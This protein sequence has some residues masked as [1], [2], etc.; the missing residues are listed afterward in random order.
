[1][2]THAFLDA[3]FIWSLGVDALLIPRD[4]RVPRD[5]TD[6]STLQCPDD[7]DT[8]LPT[9]TYGGTGGIFT[10][11]AELLINAPAELIYNTLIDFKSYHIWN[12]FV[13]NVEVPSNVTNT[14]DDVY[15]NMP[16]TFTTSGL[17]PLINTT[18]DETVTFL[19][20]DAD[21]GYLLN[22]WSA[23]VPSEHP[24]ILVSQGGGVTRYVSYETFYA[25]LGIAVL[26]LKSELQKQFEQQ[27]EDLR[28]YVESMV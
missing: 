11:C 16:M 2:R 8:I 27:G 20:N 18:S 24:N 14:P 17:L 7:T 5:T 22:A 26:I 3:V 23:S 25:P 9:P 19:E 1:M 4:P 28:T 12:S 15:I 13:I 10:V 6:W 21:A